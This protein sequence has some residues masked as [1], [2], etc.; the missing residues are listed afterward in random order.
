M[1]RLYAYDS[2]ATGVTRE[3]GSDALRAPAL[4]FGG[5]PL[6]KVRLQRLAVLGLEQVRADRTAEGRSVPYS[7]DAILAISFTVRKAPLS[8]PSKTSCMC[9]SIDRQGAPEGRLGA[10]ASRTLASGDLRKAD[11]T[12]GETFGASPRGDSSV[13]G[14]FTQARYCSTCSD[15]LF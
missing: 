5:D 10:A 14:V 4:A 1:A 2:R 12:T 13:S 8:R 7:T 9:F 3:C 15:R 11:R 6:V